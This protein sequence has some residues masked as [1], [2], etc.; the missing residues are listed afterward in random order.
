MY[1][2]KSIY[3]LRVNYSKGIE[4]KI[5]TLSNCHSSSMSNLHLKININY[6]L[7]LIKN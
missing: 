7:M 2:P 6:V 3:K 4:K 5:N 1:K